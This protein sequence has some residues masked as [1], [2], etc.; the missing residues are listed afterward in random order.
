MMTKKYGA[1]FPYLVDDF[2]M[3]T[4]PFTWIIINLW[5]WPLYEAV[6]VHVVLA[7]VWSSWIAINL[8]R[9]F[10]WNRQ[11]GKR[12]LWAPT[13]QSE[14]TTHALQIATEETCGHQAYSST[15]LAAFVFPVPFSL[16]YY[17][18]E[19]WRKW[20]VRGYGEDPDTQIRNSEMDAAIA[21]AEAQ[22]SNVF[23]ADVGSAFPSSS[24]AAGD[25]GSGG[26]VDP[27][28][29]L[30]SDEPNPFDDPSDS[31]SAPALRSP[32]APDISPSHPLLP[33]SAHHDSAL[34]PSHGDLDDN[35]FEMSPAPSGVVPSDEASMSRGNDDEA[36][37]DAEEYNL[38]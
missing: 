7:M 2:S 22:G 30:E 21:M 23:E 25:A 10:W 34:S 28:E 5:Y 3:W 24:A 37:R 9:V 31:V 4:A 26:V 27:S 17:L 38:V 1:E 33:S 14:R 35:A 29:S 32:D 15:L 18:K 11:N 13:K 6:A 36:Q 12:G 8:Y 20:Q 19:E 16:Y